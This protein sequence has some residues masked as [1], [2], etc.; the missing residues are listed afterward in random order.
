ML[1]ALGAII[2][3][4][5]L[6]ASSG[7][8]DP[9]NG[10]Y[11]LRNSQKRQLS[12]HSIKSAM[13]LDTVPAPK[14]VHIPGTDEENPVRSVELIPAE[15][16]TKDLADIKKVPRARRQVKPGVLKNVIKVTPVKI[17]K[18]KIIKR[19]SPL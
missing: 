4:A 9:G 13:L 16:K 10:F 19:I 7:P 2:L 15:K 6:F 12:L 3:P 5:A 1:T 8:I 14:P 18:P 17:V 11:Q